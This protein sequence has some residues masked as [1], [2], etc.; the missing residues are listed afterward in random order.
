MLMQRR[1][2]THSKRP[3]CPMYIREPL[4]GRWSCSGHAFRPCVGRAQQSSSVL[5]CSLTSSLALGCLSLRVA[6]DRNTHLGQCYIR[7]VASVRTSVS[8]KSKDATVPTKQRQ[9]GRETPPPKYAALAALKLPLYLRISVLRSA[10]QK[11]RCPGPRCPDQPPG[12]S[13]IF[14]LSTRS[15]G[16]PSGKAPLSHISAHERTGR[17]AT[18]SYH[19]V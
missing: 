11:C 10:N 5:H 13:S 16:T 12:S 1:R 15:T 7:W 2:Y 19:G 9:Q 6:E 8:K 18:R 3:K 14:Q 4:H 17:S